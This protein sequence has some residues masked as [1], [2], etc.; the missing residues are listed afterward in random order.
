SERKKYWAILLT[1]L[2]NKSLSKNFANHANN[3]LEEWWNNE[4][5]ILK[6]A[7]QYANV[8]DAEI[9]K[10]LAKFSIEYLP[11]SR[12]EPSRQLVLLQRLKNF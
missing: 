9:D 6:E 7:L 1:I 10:L 12:H 11:V 8:D 2:D 4:L 5:S 3:Q